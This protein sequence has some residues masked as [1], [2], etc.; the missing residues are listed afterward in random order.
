METQAQVRDRMTYKLESCSPEL[1]LKVSS[2]YEK[3]VREFHKQ[4]ESKKQDSDEARLKDETS[5]IY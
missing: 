3:K 4:E 1:F 5:R 2:E